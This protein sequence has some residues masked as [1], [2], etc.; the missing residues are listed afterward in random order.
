MLITYYRIDLNIITAILLVI[1]N[2][3]ARARLDR[4][5]QL[6]RA[7]NT[8]TWVVIIELMIEASTCLINGQPYPWLIPVSIFLHMCLFVTAP[9]LALYWFLLIRRMLISTP[10]KNIWYSLLLYIP[11]ILSVGLSFLSPLFDFVFY[12]DSANV[13]HRG[14]LFIYEMGVIFFYLLLAF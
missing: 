9:I 1:I 11:A 10:K 4:K 7:F 6:N 14:V 2:F 13:Y 3:L 8:I 5:D 12:I